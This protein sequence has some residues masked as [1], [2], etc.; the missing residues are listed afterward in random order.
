[1]IRYLAPSLKGEE[2]GGHSMTFVR[3]KES[4]FRFDGQKV[5]EVNEE[6]I[7]RLYG[8]SDWHTSVLVIYEAE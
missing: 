5:E 8:S 1:M 2:G 3:V 7:T 6:A 4:S